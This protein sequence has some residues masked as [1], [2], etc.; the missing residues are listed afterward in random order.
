MLLFILVV[1]FVN[2]HDD[3]NLYTHASLKII[4]IEYSHLESGWKT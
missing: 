2:S 1:A 3:I 4:L